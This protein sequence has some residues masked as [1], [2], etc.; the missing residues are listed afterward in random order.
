VIYLVDLP[1][2]EQLRFAAACSNALEA[3]SH[4]M[5][6]GTLSSGEMA[7]TAT[8]RAEAEMRAACG[9][10]ALFAAPSSTVVL[11]ADHQPRPAPLQRFLRLMPVASVE[12]LDSALFP[13]REKLSNAAIAGFTPEAARHIG[14][15]ASRH[16]VSRIT[17]PGRLQTPPVDWPHDGMPLLTPLCRFVQSD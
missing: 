11:E 5:P 4:D 10:G 12:E 13:F 3:L 15:L 8:E 1:V 17:H 14:D 16:S 2:D 6:R 9:R 7:S